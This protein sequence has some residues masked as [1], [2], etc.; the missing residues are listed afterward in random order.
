MSLKESKQKSRE[1]LRFLNKGSSD[2]FI[3]L[4]SNQPTLYP[5]S[6]YNDSYRKVERQNLAGKNNVDIVDNI[7]LSKRLMDID[8]TKYDVPED[9]GN[10]LIN[11][12]ERSNF[13]VLDELELEIKTKMKELKKLFSEVTQLKINDYISE[14]DYR[15]SVLSQR[16]RMMEFSNKITYLKLIVNTIKGYHKE[17][18][19]LEDYEALSTEDKPDMSF[20][21]T[22]YRQNQ[23]AGS[24]R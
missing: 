16:K 13:D 23:G 5:G 21:F 14:D 11:Y 20:L 18:K 9:I 2:D 1:I 19:E 8:K 12:I 4:T 10:K 7:E 6:N 17:I 22:D 3:G 24:M 15:R